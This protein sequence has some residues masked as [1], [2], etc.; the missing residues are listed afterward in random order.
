MENPWRVN[1]VDSFKYR[2]SVYWRFHPVP[3]LVY[4]GV[5]TP[6]WHFVYIGGSTPFRYLCILTFP[7][8]P[9]T[10][11]I[12]AVPP[13]LGTCVRLYN[14]YLIVLTFRHLKNEA[15]KWGCITNTLWYWLLGTRHHCSNV[16]T[17]SATTPFWNFIFS[18]FAVVERLLHSFRDAHYMEH[19]NDLNFLFVSESPPCTS[20]HPEREHGSK[21]SIIECYLK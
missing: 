18:A 5:S 9:G 17:L 19:W 21:V 15:V 13:R 1:K 20:I 4:T 7:P 2:L 3:A 14:Q 10:L 16:S 11:C 12:S 8:R 6:S